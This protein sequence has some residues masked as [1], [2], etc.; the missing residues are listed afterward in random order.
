M[1]K[2]FKEYHTQLVAISTEDKE[3]LAKFAKANKIDIPILSDPDHSIMAALHAWKPKK[4]FHGMQSKGDGVERASFVV[5]QSGQVVDEI[6]RH[7]PVGFSKRAIKAVAHVQGVRVPSAIFKKKGGS[8][9]AKGSS[10]KSAKK[11]KD[12]KED[13][14]DDKG[15]SSE[16]KSSSEEDGKGSSGSDEKSSSDDDD[17]K[18]KKISKKK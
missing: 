5:D 15:S 16:G 8:S 3:K 1:Q 11:S 17:D 13:D 9:K 4:A 2:H 18:K 10:K 12:E 6:R 14:D 7:R